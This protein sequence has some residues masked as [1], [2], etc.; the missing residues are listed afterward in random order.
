MSES[1]QTGGAVAPA[2][3]TTSTPDTK[4]GAAASTPRQEGGEPRQESPAD[5]RQQKHKVKVNGAESEIPY[6]ELIRGYQSTQAANQRFQEAQR[7][8]QEGTKAKQDAAAINEALDKGDVKFLVNRLGPQKAREIFESYLIEQM[9]EERLPQHEKD[10]RSE[11]KKREDLE[12]RIKE[13]ETAQ[14]RQRYQELEQQAY[15]DLDGMIAEALRTGG[16]KKP[17]PRLALRI[18]EQHES[19][20]KANGQLLPPDKLWQRAEAGIREDIALIAPDLSYAEAKD[21]FGEKVLDRWMKEKL[22]QVMDQRP[23]PPARRFK[24]DTEE[25]APVN[26]ALSIDDKFAQME[27]QLKKRR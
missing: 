3:P 4:G 8:Q 5:Y 6:D 2:A 17:N 20:L 19:E 15:Q 26:Q 27:Q 10:L 11:R 16:N 13:Q 22:G 21:L 25:R 7:L 14:Q 18:I 1:Q 9:E 23:K 24:P 12:A